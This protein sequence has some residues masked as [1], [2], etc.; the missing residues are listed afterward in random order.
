ME[1]MTNWLVW[2]GWELRV[3]VISMQTEFAGK[4]IPTIGWYVTER[5][6]VDILRG[7][8]SRWWTTDGYNQGQTGVKKLPGIRS[9][10]GLPFQITPF[11]LLFSLPLSPFLPSFPLPARKWPSNPARGSGRALWAPPAD[12]NTFLVYFEH[13]KRIWWQPFWF[14]LSSH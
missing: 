10:K 12:T 3:P 4:L 11:L 7:K 14:H 9:I 8:G 6:V 2:I 5:A 1:E 13:S